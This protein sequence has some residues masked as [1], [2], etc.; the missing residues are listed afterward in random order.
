MSLRADDRTEGV[1]HVPSGQGE[2]VWVAGDTYTIKAGTADTNGTLAFL[3]ATVPPGGG[4]QPHIHTAEDEALYVL[5][6]ELEV[7][8]GDKPLAAGAGDFVFIPR[9]TLHRFHNVGVHAV[10]MVLLFTPAGFDQFFLDAG[11]RAIPGE[12]IPV[13]G[14]E[15]F[16][17]AGEIA[18]RYTWRS[19]PESPAPDHT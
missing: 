14:P 10:R 4:P 17:R 18:S 11:D 5:S 16:E 1:L 7:L 9:G 13:W 6:G 3:E 2:S 15:Q 8:N 19:G 12:P